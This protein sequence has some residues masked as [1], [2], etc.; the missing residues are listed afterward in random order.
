[1]VFG[2]ESCLS[3]HDNNNVLTG[4]ASDNW[5]LGNCGNDVLVCDLIGGPNRTDTFVIDGAVG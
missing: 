3:V 4:S 2:A 1:M 5:L